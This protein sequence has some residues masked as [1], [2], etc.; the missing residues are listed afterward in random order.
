MWTSGRQGEP[1]EIILISPVVQAI[2]IRLLSTMS[3]R[4]R[5]LA[6]NAVAFRRNVGWNV[7]PAMAPTSRSTRVLHTAYEVSGFTGDSS[8]TGSEPPTPYTLHEDM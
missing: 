6:P 1:S 3:N 4:I 7:S 8:V 2:P 5:G